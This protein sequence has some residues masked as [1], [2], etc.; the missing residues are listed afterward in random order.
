MVNIVLNPGE[1]VSVSFAETDGSFEIHFDTKEHPNAVVVKE[2]GGMPG[3]VC[4]K[5]FE[6]MHHEQFEDGEPIPAA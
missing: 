3:N 2:T 4:G 1:A 5:A 6:I